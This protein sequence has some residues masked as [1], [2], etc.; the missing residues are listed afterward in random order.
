MLEHNPTSIAAVI[1]TYN[2]LGLLKACLASVRAQTRKPDQIIVVNNGSTDG[3]G[4][5]LVQQSD[6][7]TITQANLGSGGGQYTGIKT[8][9]ERGYDWSWCMDDDGLPAPD[10]LAKLCVAISRRPDARIFNSLVIDKQ[11]HGRIAF[12]YW[13]GRNIKDRCSGKRYDLV[14]KLLAETSD[15]IL[16]GEGQFFNCTL[17][18]RDVVAAIGLPLPQLFIRGDEVEYLL[19]SQMYGFRT[20]TVTD[21]LAFHP[22]PA[23]R[24]VTIFSKKIDYE[25][26]ADWKRYY[27]S[28]NTIFIDRTYHPTSYSWIIPVRRILFGIFVELIDT[29][30][31]ISE[32][33]KSCI[34]VI[35]GVIDGLSFAPSDTIETV[36]K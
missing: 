24:S 27:N 36:S 7:I 4:S 28:R 8:A 32:K 33:W 25:P 5:W 20:L 3:T 11:N 12:G 1:V 23:I 31:S 15:T 30:K 2:R 19:R 29:R 6:V 18:H 17:L 10:A 16:D 26:M 9:F 35:K 21:S 14:E 22:N 13:L 34:T